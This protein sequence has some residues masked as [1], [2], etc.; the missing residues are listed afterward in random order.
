MLLARGKLA[1]GHRSRST[2]RRRVSSPALPRRTIN[3]DKFC[4]GATEFPRGARPHGF[5]GQNLLYR[6]GPAFSLDMTLGMWRRPALRGGTRRETGWRSEVGGSGARGAGRAR[7]GGGG[8][9]AGAG[10]VRGGGGGGG[11]VRGGVGVGGGGN[12][13][14]TRVPGYRSPPLLLPPVVR[15]ECGC[16]VLTGG[17]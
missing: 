9:A 13:A 10:R 5:G 1:S 3:Q 7:A 12:A 4:R 17:R 8:R 16:Q 15:F 11:C 14:R 2:E 6:E